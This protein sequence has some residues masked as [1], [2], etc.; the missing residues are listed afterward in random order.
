MTT[1][2]PPAMNNPQLD[3]LY[4]IYNPSAGRGRAL[5][6]LKEQLER[7]GAG[8]TLKPTDGPGHAETLAQEAA[9]AGCPLV[10]AAGGDGT[11]HEVANGIL[12]AENPSCA[13]VVLPVGSAND[14]A[15]SLGLQ[16]NWWCDDSRPATFRQVDV[17][18][19]ETNLGSNRYF[20]NGAGIGLNGAVTLESRSIRGLQGVLLY[21][22][23]M[24]RA[25]WRRYRYPPLIVTLDGVQRE[26]TPTLAFSASIGKREGNFLLAPD[27]E[28]DDGLFDYLHA[29][30]I[31]WWE[32][33]R[34]LPGM[35][36]GRLPDNHPA[37]WRGR[38]RDVHVQADD[39]LIIHVDGEMFA[40]PGDGVR[41]VH[42]TML[43]GRL[44]ICG[45][46]AERPA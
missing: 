27:A 19:I 13:L 28:V 12:R 11:V 17:G 1:Q 45:R 29:G 10:G 31:K 42:I 15:Y 33:L 23:A 43:P 25:L 14:Y 4:V 38:C 22:T 37:L 20:V 39:D 36:R 35:I 21:S 8:I 18:L 30:P 26:R 7:L 6:R 16:A 44:R 41:D 3:Q 9:E 46:F 32:V 34:Y 2:R 24:L 40:L 5:A